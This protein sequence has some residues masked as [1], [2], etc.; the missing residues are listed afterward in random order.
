MKE[1]IG[2]VFGDNTNAVIPKS[3]LT[4]G[5]SSSE[6]KSCFW[7]AKSAH[8]KAQAKIEPNSKWPTYNCQI[9]TEASTFAKCERKMYT[10]TDGSTSADDEVAEPL[11]APVPV[12]T[13][14][15]ASAP[16]KCPVEQREALP[17][18]WM[19]RIERIEQEQS[20]N[21]LAIANKMDRM[22]RQLS[23]LISLA[24]M[25]SVGASEA[26]QAPATS[27]A[28]LDNIAKDPNLIQ[29]LQP[30]IGSNS[31][32]TV[33]RVLKRCMSRD[34]ALHF[35]FTGLG[36][37][38]TAS[39]QAFGSHLLCT[40]I[41]GDAAALQMKDT[42]EVLVNHIQAALR[43]ARDWDG[44]RKLRLDAAASLSGVGSSPLRATV[45]TAG[46]ISCT[47]PAGSGSG[48]RSPVFLPS[49]VSIPDIEGAGAAAI[50]YDE[51]E[52]PSPS[53]GNSTTG[54]VWN[55]SIE[56]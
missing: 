2:V 28:E 44:G 29:K 51:V 25:K 38:R 32:M 41:L 22:E 12:L 49:T 9:L 24:E 5:S 31:K 20:R 8:H 33:R 34:L 40:R 26:L 37:K 19:E 15:P 10:L 53:A 14:T 4:P 16:R 13:F 30:Y 46:V 48:K 55:D 17:E 11:V 35:S 52:Q 6:S 47:S 7:P 39:K 50:T 1:F 36:E 43:G 56:N 27:M 3:W 54:D 42:R 45:S 23:H 21:H 18:E